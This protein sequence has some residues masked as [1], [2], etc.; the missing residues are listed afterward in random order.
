MGMGP[1]RQGIDTVYLVSRDLE[2]LRFNVQ[3]TICLL[4]RVMSA[5]LMSE[6]I[7]WEENLSLS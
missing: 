6:A 3:R 5:M 7:R 2:E 1:R 4:S